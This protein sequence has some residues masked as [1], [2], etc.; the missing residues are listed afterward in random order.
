[1]HVSDKHSLCVSHSMCKVQAALILTLHFGVLCG[2]GQHGEGLFGLER[3]PVF[4]KDDVQK[5][6]CHAAS[7]VQEH[8]M[9][10]VHL[11]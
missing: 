3:Y 2:L 11:Q 6:R 4:L 9:G 5:R 8:N 10:T 1:M 7:V